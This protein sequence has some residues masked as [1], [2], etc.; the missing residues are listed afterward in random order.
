MLRILRIVGT[1][2]FALTLG[3]AANS[4]HLMHDEQGALSEPNPVPWAGIILGAVCIAGLVILGSFELRRLIRA[5]RKHRQSHRSRSMKKDPNAE[6]EMAQIWMMVLRVFSVALPFAYAGIFAVVDTRPF[7]Q[8]LGI[9]V[10]ASIC[11]LLAV[12]AILFAVSVF[13]EGTWGWV[14]GYLLAIMNLIV[15]P[16]GTGVGLVLLLLLFGASPAMVPAARGHSR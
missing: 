14:T 6:P 9:W 7:L 15:F 11:L 10:F 4:V 8:T 3:F 5:S 2:C 16:V 12:L 1:I 13:I